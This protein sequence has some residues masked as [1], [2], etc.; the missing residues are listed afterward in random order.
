MPPLP[1]SR[2]AKTIDLFL[3]TFGTDGEA[4]QSRKSAR[5]DWETTRKGRTTEG[6]RQTATA[7]KAD[8]GTEQDVQRDGTYAHTKPS[9]DL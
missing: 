4:Y 7:R 3:L 9:L 8:E 5:T 1:K 2:Q 6:Q